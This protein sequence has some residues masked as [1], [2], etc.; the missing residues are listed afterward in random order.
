MF[1]VAL[2]ILTNTPLCS[3]L[4]LSSR[5]IFLGFGAS[6]LI[7]QNNVNTPNQ[8]TLNFEF[9]KPDANRLNL[10]SNSNNKGHF[11]CV[12]NEEASILLGGAYAVNQTLVCS[13]SSLPVLL[14]I[15]SS[16]LSKSSSFGFGFGSSVLDTLCEFCVSLLFLKN[17]FWDNSGSK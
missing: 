4:S 11:W 13:F 16:G 5:K 8:N 2:L 10:P 14:S 1:Q 9:Q 6:L 15:G 7:L 3:C 17:V 12:G